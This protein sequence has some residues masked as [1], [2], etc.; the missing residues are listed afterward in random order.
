MFPFFRPRQPNRFINIF[1]KRKCP[2]KAQYRVTFKYKTNFSGDDLFTA[3]PENLSF[4]VVNL[5]KPIEVGDLVRYTPKKRH[6]NKDHLARVIRV[7]RRLRNISRGQDTNI[8]YSLFFIRAPEINGLKIKTLKTSDISELTLVP[9]LEAYICEKDFIEGNIIVQFQNSKTRTRRL[10]SRKR[11]LKRKIKKSGKF[12]FKNGRIAYPKFK[13]DAISRK[14]RGK[15]NEHV[16]NIVK[17]GFIKDML[18]T[19]TL[20]K[21]QY[22]NKKV[23]DLEK[24]IKPSQNQEFKVLNVEI[25]KQN[26]NDNF[27]FKELSSFNLDAQTIIFDLEVHVQINL[28]IKDKLSDE[29]LKSETFSGR[30]LRGAKNFLLNANSY[31][32]C[33]TNRNN[34]KRAVNNIFSGGKKKTRKRRKFYKMKTHIKKTRKR[35]IR[36]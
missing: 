23:L 11:A 14:V 26:N 30:T 7:R 29:E 10:R 12:V 2:R 15:L 32:G 28:S 21:G 33:E 20:I 3:V 18:F 19:P 25:I 1:P 36:K 8:Q 16:D 27:K 24:M 34:I 22:T 5:N 35:K 9:E 31:I 13:N 17:T 4:D 6:Q